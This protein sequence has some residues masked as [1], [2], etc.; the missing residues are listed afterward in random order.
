MNLA[1]YIAG[2]IINQNPQP[3]QKADLISTRPIVKVAITGIS[4]GFIV[5]LVAVC[6]LFGFQ[7]EIR[8][9]VIGFG[10]HL[11]ITSYATDNSFQTSPISKD[12]AFVAKIKTLPEVKHIYPFAIKPG[13]IKTNEDIEGVV[14]K[15]VNDD[16]DWSFISSKIL[17]GHTPVYKAG[18]KS[19]EVVIS[20][21]V[22][23]KLKIKLN[24]NLFMYF[25]QQPPRM[26][27]FKV[28][29]IYQTGLEE[30]DKLYVFGDMSH[31]QK[32]NDWNTDLITGFEINIKDF[33]KLTE[34]NAEINN[35]ISYD[36]N[37]QNIR[38]LYPQ[39]FD[40]LKLQ[41]INVEIIL[42][43]MLL[44]CSI[45]MISALLIM[46]LERT[47]FIGILKALG[48]TN[49]SVQ[50]VFLFNAVYLIS[51]GLFW[52]NIIGIGLCLIQKIFHPVQL[53]QAS[54]YVK[55][56]PIELNLWIIIALNAGTLL[57]CTIM[58]IL[59]TLIITRIT[60]VKAIRFA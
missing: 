27:K 44:V 36:M 42:V 49:F 5:M 2:K 22:A 43:L 30:Y 53:D 6:I 47:N 4:I 37:C 1:R 9:K 46:I 45:N 57:L 31:I 58:M 19:D 23:D 35:L 39:I 40:W 33:N 60:P 24:D 34:V 7:K 25:I 59:P 10:G 41:N 52:G 3:Q 20:K 50:K 55:Y 8:D 18:E 32:L 13:I 14:L 48:A 56:V 21:Q 26:R 28:T 54:Y 29:G 16:Y 11:V 12:Q 38:Q 15:G 51:K 17:E